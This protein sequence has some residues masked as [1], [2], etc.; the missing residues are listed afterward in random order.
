MG[1]RLDLNGRRPHG[2]GTELGPAGF[3]RLVAAGFVEYVKLVA[4]FLRKQDQ[5]TEQL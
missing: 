4:A 5:S 3:V 1:Q 2:E